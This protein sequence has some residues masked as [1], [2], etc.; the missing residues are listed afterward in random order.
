MVR[1]MGAALRKSLGLPVVVLWMTTAVWF[2]DATG[3]GV[4]FSD[5]DPD[6]LLRALGRMLD[7]AGPRAARRR[8]APRGENELAATTPAAQLLRWSAHARPLTAMPV[9]RIDTQLQ[10]E[11]GATSEMLPDDRRLD[12][13]ASD[14]TRCGG[15]AAW[16]T[17][18]PATSFPQARSGWERGSDIHR[19]FSNPLR[20]SVFGDATTLECSRALVT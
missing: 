11:S 2:I 13:A 9:P 7:P 19:S 18:C 20:S 14:F 5:R 3:A 6:D 16:T 1:Q 4:R 10:Q 8:R 15:S 12:D 17:W